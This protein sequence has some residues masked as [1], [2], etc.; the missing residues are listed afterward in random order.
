MRIASSALIGAGAL[1]LAACGTTSQPLT[2]QDIAEALPDYQRTGET[3][4]CLSVTRVDEIDPVTE[5]LWLVETR[6]G[7]IYLNQVSRGCN[8]ADSSFNYLSYELPTGQLCRGEIV[9]VV[10]ATGD[11]VVGSCSLGE[12]ER[13][14]PAE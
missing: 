5:R 8:G 9:R 11:F 6:G 10:Q 2:D 4:S 14:I 1:A 3:A 12:Y 7:E 13:L